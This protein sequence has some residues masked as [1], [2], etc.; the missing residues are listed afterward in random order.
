MDTGPEIKMLIDRTDPFATAKPDGRRPAPGQKR[1]ELRVGRFLAMRCAVVELRDR[2][3]ID[4]RRS[5][6]PGPSQDGDKC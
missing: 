4:A 3:V 6:R 5:L 1:D 2:V